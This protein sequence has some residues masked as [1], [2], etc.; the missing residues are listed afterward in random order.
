MFTLKILNQ[1]KR[2]DG[3]IYGNYHQMV[4]S[5][6]MPARFRSSREKGETLV[7]SR[8]LR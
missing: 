3:V 8:K 1:L 4:R 7:A 6:I 2:K 5:E